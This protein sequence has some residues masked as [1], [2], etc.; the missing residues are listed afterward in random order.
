MFS[1]RRNMGNRFGTN[2]YR[3]ATHT[4]CLL[5]FVISRAK[6]GFKK[7]AEDARDDR[8]VVTESSGW[9]GTL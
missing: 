4:R 2:I 8:I 7:V 6:P 1:F 9:N 5:F 3:P